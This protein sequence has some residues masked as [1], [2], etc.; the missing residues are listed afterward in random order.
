MNQMIENLFDKY[1]NI[2]NNS[3]SDIVNAVMNNDCKYIL[4]Y[5]KENDIDVVD[6]KLENLLHKAARNDNV[7]VVKMLIELNVDVNA[8]NRHLDT[9]L[10][11][12]IISKNLSVFN[13]LLENK[14]RINIK[15]K[16]NVSPI[17]LAAASG[18]VKMLNA[19][20]DRGASIN[21]ADE[22][23]LKP[24]HY[25]I[26][27]GKKEMIQ[28][29]LDKGASIMEVDDRKNNALHHAASRGKDNIIPYLL[30][31]M[32]ISESFNIYGETALHLAALNC[33][34]LTLVALV[35]AGFGLD[36]KNGDGKTPYELA[37]ENGRIENADILEKISR[38]PEYRDHYLKYPLHR[39]IY[40]N[41][42]TYVFEN[43]NENNVNDLDFF[44]K[45]MLY[46]AVVKNLPRMIKA[47]L[48]KNADINSI[49][50]LH[51]SALLIA[52]FT[53][54]IEAIDL[55]LANGANPNEIF[56]KR[57]YLYRAIIRNNYELVKV[58]IK[59]GA[60]VNYIDSNHRSLFSYAI[61]NAG[62][63]I[64]ELLMKNKF[65]NL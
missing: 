18:K 47:L 23:G 22:N 54:N 48:D 25:A 40:E 12:A 36:V 2:G 24:L 52:V 27:S 61:E 10:H 39:A 56:Y 20:L 60:N 43:V 32:V 14:A 37:I 46:Y 59:N 62:H 28:L 41:N 5:I 65:G 42:E 57:S 19:L 31:Q 30:E 15:N 21:I 3:S 6:A 49:D 34:P 13:V 50:S 38:N 44:G 29:L 33:Q 51:Q 9:P 8:H 45:S 55:L 16:K 4:E 1:G 53:E 64:V 26:R 11:L 35:N 58:L 63:D 17:H 7:E